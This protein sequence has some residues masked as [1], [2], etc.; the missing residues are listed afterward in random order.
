MATYNLHGTA[1]GTE[2]VYEY[3]RRRFAELLS[4]FERGISP[5]VT[6]NKDG[7]Y[8]ASKLIFVEL[9]KSPGKV[10]DSLPPDAT[11]IESYLNNPSNPI[12]WVTQKARQTVKEAGHDVAVNLDKPAQWAKDVGDSLPWYVKPGA[13]V[14]IIAAAVILPPLFGHSLKGIVAGMKKR[15]RTR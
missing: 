5:G 4:N 10:T 3:A 14:G 6:D 2:T 11:Y 1:T 12:A 7:A 9:K 8:A 13:L 15:K